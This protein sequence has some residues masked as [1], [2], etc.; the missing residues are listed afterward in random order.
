MTAAKIFDFVN[1]NVALFNVRI[2]LKYTDSLSSFLF[3]ED[4]FAYLPLVFFNETVGRTHYGLCGTVVLFQLKY[5]G[6]GIDLGKIE[7][8]IN[9][10]T[11]ERINTLGI[12][13]HHTNV[14][15]FAGQLLHNAVLCIIGILILVDQ[16][17][18]EL[19]AV[20]CQHVRMLLKQYPGVEQ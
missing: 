4:L 20:T 9:V 17:V 12:I 6:I 2:G 10:G 8:V 5:A 19:L 11:T 14:L 3:R 15:M 7:N 18:T 13:T 1:H 16:H